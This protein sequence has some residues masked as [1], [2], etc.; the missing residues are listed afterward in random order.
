[1]DGAGDIGR[2]RKD[3]HLR[4]LRDPHNSLIPGN[5]GLQ[6]HRRDILQKPVVFVGRDLVRRRAAASDIGRGQ[7]HDVDPGVPGLAHGGIHAV[8]D[9]HVTRCQRGI[10]LRRAIVAAAVDLRRIAFALVGHFRGRHMADG[11]VRIHL[12]ARAQGRGRLLGHAGDDFRIVVRLPQQSGGFL[13]VLLAEG[14]RM[15]PRVLRMVFHGLS[16]SAPN[17][18]G[19]I[20]GSQTIPELPAAGPKHPESYSKATRR[21]KRWPALTTRGQLAITR[22]VP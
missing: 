6:H 13:V 4:H 1:M 7:T 8:G 22:D 3:R 9:Q 21:G 11:R 17:G 18:E 14:Q 16:S 15:P 19:S 5:M 10:I 20:P 2:D 12:A